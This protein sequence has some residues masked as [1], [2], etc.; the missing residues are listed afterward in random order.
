MG[1]YALVIR[2][3]VIHAIWPMRPRLMRHYYIRTVILNWYFQVCTFLFLFLSSS[4]PSLKYKLK[5]KKLSPELRPY[6][7]IY[8]ARNHSFEIWPQCSNFSFF[9]VEILS[10]I[11]SMD[12]L[13]DPKF[14]LTHVDKKFFY[15]KVELSASLLVEH[16]LILS[17]AQRRLQVPVRALITSI[18]SS[19]FSVSLIWSLKHY[20]RV[21][22]TVWSI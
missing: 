21:K 8:I 10:T 14:S 7:R 20:F 5:R 19:T 9:I 1:R 18:C 15:S 11:K 17:F 4:I 3:Q 13:T 12:K 22:C 6:H 16:G 2:M